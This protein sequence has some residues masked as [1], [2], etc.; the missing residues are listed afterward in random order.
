MKYF[1]RKITINNKRLLKLPTSGPYSQAIHTIRE[2]ISVNKHR[3]MMFIN[4][5]LIFKLNICFKIFML[6]YLKPS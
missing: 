5:G 6:N 3:S 2:Q 4:C 1:I